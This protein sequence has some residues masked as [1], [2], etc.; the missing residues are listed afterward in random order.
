MVEDGL[1]FSRQLHRQQGPAALTPPASDPL[2]SYAA[3]HREGPGLW[4]W[5]HY[6]PIY[7]RHLQRFVGTDVHV[8]EI[9]VLG[10]GSLHM[11]RSYFGSG[12]TIY[13]SDIN[14]ECRKH[15]SEGFPILIG[16]QADPTFW[17]E[18]LLELPRLDVV[19]D[20]GGHKPEQ[21]VA[22]LKA[23]LPAMSR[24]GVYICE[25]VH[26]ALIGFRLFA[27]GIAHA[28]GDIGAMPTPA[29][30]VH[31]H[32]ESVHHYA[33]LTVIEKPIAPVREFDAPRLGTAWP[34]DAA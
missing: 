9:G 30:A 17:E 11:W 22:S 32:V 24:G 12:A 33:G 21:Q 13:G 15:A 5:Q 20:D 10:G 34:D 29:A 31:Q 1:R 8:L 2:A 26:G 28:I 3:Q 4:K 16:D 25:D 19:I 18:V 7:H 27:D 14:P 6:L 23:L